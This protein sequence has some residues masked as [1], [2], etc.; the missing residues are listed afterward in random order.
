MRHDA[1]TTEI[2]AI[3]VPAGLNRHV[4]V[5]PFVRVALAGS[6]EQPELVVIEIEDAPTQFGGELSGSWSVV[7]IG[8]FV[9]PARVVKNGEQGDDIDLRTCF[10]CQSEAI[11][12]DSGPVR[13]AVIA[14]ERECV[15]F[16]NGVENGEE[17]HVVI[18][19]L[20]IRP[21]P[22]SCS[23]RRSTFASVYPTRTV[24]VVLPDAVQR[25][26]D[27]SFPLL[28]LVLETLVDPDCLPFNVYV[29]EHSVVEQIVFIIRYRP[30]VYAFQATVKHVEY[31]DDFLPA[32][33]WVAFSGATFVC[34]RPVCSPHRSHRIVALA[35][36][37]DP[38]AAANRA[39]FDVT[40]VR[41]RLAHGHAA[42]G[43]VML[44]FH[45]RFPFFSRKVAFA[46]LAF[47]I[48][49]SQSSST[50]L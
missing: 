9:D 14:P 13:N 11:L 31:F 50:G 43:A 27:C 22:P 5:I 1:D 6:E 36:A 23:F 44:S 17:V 30:H 46:A 2:E 7:G 35:I 16:E 40:F 47:L 12:K 25:P 49:H 8:D 33:V 42:V 10:F 38:L 37:S 19:P 45:L 18:L 26:C 20:A 28:F 32:D 48:S 21:T 24:S 15:I 41:V 4:G 34:A 29:G 3:R 39:A